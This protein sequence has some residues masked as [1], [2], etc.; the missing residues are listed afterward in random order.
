MQMKNINDRAE[1]MRKEIAL[2][3]KE[4]IDETNQLLYK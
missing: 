2:H 4:A 3:R 1:L